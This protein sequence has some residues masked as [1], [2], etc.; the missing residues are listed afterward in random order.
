MR[1]Y[2]VAKVKGDAYGFGSLLDKLTTVKAANYD[3][4]VDKAVRK[5][6]LKKGDTLSI[7]A[8]QG[9]M[10][11]VKGIGLPGRYEYEI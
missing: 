2:S 6:H 3:T 9:S 11:Q 8:L 5:L 10:P 7:I 1:Q 4:A